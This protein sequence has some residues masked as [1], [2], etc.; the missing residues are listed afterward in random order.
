MADVCKMRNGANANCLSVVGQNHSMEQGIKEDERSESKNFRDQ[1]RLRFDSHPNGP[2]GFFH[3]PHAGYIE[4]MF[5]SNKSILSWRRSLLETMGKRTAAH[6][7]SSHLHID[8]LI[9]LQTNKKKTEHSLATGVRKRINLVVLLTSLHMYALVLRASNSRN[10]CF[11][12]RFLEWHFLRWPLSYITQ[13]THTHCGERE[14]WRRPKR[15][16]IDEA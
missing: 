6:R 14:S 3:S 13:H 8:F 12:R 4:L 9:E 2:S 15:M 16:A 11:Y 7:P 10:M 5:F 1:K